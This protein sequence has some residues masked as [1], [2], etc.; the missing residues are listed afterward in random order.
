M[1]FK[2]LEVPV[3]IRNQVTDKKKGGKKDTLN[4]KLP[5][6]FIP[7]IENIHI[8]KK[9]WNEVIRKQTFPYSTVLRI[10]TTPTTYRSIGAH[11]L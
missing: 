3:L 1:L 10:K 5:K 6:V 11:P 4:R 7:L 2:P 9:K 8:P